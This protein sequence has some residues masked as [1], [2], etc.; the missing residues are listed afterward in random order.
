LEEKIIVHVESIAPLYNHFQLAL[1][2]LGYYL[3]ASSGKGHGIHSPFVFDFII[4]VLN[5]DK[6]SDCYKPIE[7]R[8][9]ELLRN[10]DIL[11]VEDFGAGS[12][13]IRTTQRVVRDIAKS[14]LKSRKFGQLLYRMV[15]HYKPATILELG[16]LLV[17]PV[18]I[19]PAATGW[20]HYIPLKVRQLS[21][22][23]RHRHSM[24]FR[25]TMLS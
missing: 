3:T 17:L 21:P 23:S 6:P 5:D 2:Y 7:Q 25:S 24:P 4:N 13:T 10:K 19:L 12:A 14:S 15:R 11:E 16:L 18:P 1:K 9:A 22:V 8:R 20:G